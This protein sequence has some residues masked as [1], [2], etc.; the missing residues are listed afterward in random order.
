MLKDR[1][2][3]LR[4][5]MSWTQNDLADAMNV[6]RSTI[7]MWEVGAVDLPISVIATLAL[8]LN[9][10][11]AYLTQDEDIGMA[12]VVKKATAYAPARMAWSKSR[13]AFAA[14]RVPID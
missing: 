10:T 13:T 11:I 7:A 12:N 2:K 6:S 4:K 1:I 9:S 8:T 5:K 3:E 14:S